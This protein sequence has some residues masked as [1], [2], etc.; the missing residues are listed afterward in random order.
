MTAA[1][2]VQSAAASQRVPRTIFYQGAFQDLD[3]DPRTGEVSLTFTIDSTAANS[4]SPLWQ[5]DTVL[6]TPDGIVS[7]LLGAISPIELS[8][9]RQYYLS[10]FVEGGLVGEPIALAATPYAFRAISA[11]SAEGARHAAISW[12][13]DSSAVSQE[14]WVARSAMMADSAFIAAAAVH[15]WQADTAL[16]ARNANVAQSAGHAD[17]SAFSQQTG[18]ADTAGFARAVKTLQTQDSLLT[19]YGANRTGVFIEDINGQERVLL[20]AGASDSATLRVRNDG[21]NKNFYLADFTSQVSSLVFTNSGELG[22]GTR[23]PTATLDAQSAN[24]AALSLARVGSVS[25]T[26]TWRMQIADAGGL[27]AKGSFALQSAASSAD[28]ALRAKNEGDPQ[29]ILKSSGRVGIGVSDPSLNLEVDGPIGVFKSNGVADMHLRA[30]DDQSVS[31]LRL[32]AG[33]KRKWSLFNDPE[34]EHA[35]KITDNEDDGKEVVRFS[36]A[37]NGNTTI[38]GDTVALG[39]GLKVRSLNYNA[40][41]EIFLSA[42]D[43]NDK[44]WFSLG[45][46]HLRT[47]DGTPYQNDTGY[48]RAITIKRFSN[49]LTTRV[50]IGTRDPSEMLDVAGSIAVNGKVMHSSD[51]RYKKDITPISDGLEKVVQLQGV[52]YRFRTDEFA[53]ENFP[54]TEQIGLIAQDVEAVVPQIVTTDEQGYKQLSY[55]KFSA[56]LIEAVKQQQGQIEHYKQKTR[57]LEDRLER[58]EQLL[59]EQ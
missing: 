44:I 12:F 11:D 27:L 50:G 55:E 9:D 13:S 28:I 52:S 1:V 22:V 17:T 49:S 8:F 39:N 37:Q 29:F 26:N 2:V 14:A 4:P 59:A 43:N 35:F 57:E 16:F 19:I 36:I 47:I 30:R 25:D 7:I 46:W 42:V 33:T 21:A 32:E 34:A 54:E 56:L 20:G 48:V 23:R 24:A 51:R 31:R 41:R 53:A 10:V 3:A 40:D 45:T 18:F 15:A 5:R 58:I 6:Q 38:S